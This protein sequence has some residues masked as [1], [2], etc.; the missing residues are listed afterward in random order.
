MSAD[1][2]GGAK[3]FDFGAHERAAV[4]AYAGVIARII[5]ECLKKRNIK[6]HSVQHRAKEPAS[7]GRKASIPSEDDPNAAKYAD[8]IKQIT[9]LA[10]VRIITHFLTTLADV[11][12]LLAEEFEVNERSDKGEELIEEERFGYQSVHFLVKIKK[13]RTRLA[14]YERF[15]G[16][17]AEVQVRTILQHAWAEIEHDIQYKSSKTIPTEIRR[18]FMAL[19]G[20]LEIADREFQAIQDADKEIETRAQAQVQSGELGGVEITPYALKL[21]LDARLGPDARISEWGYDWIARLI[22]RLGFRDLKQ[23]EA[24]I[25]PYDDDHL[26]RLA[27]GARQGQ[28]TRFELMLLAALGDRF[29]ERHHWN[30][31]EWFR[32][33]SRTALAVFQEAGVKTATYD[34]ESSSQSTAPRPI[35]KDPAVA[36]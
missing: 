3:A 35:P 29:I 8:P 20:M 25:A 9:D 30:I 33:Q 5:E 11:D 7:L 10:G 34:P 6:V 22:K 13:D 2:N 26:S 17:I 12:R 21:F 16:A 24:A 23:V 18:R 32:D 4:Q 31:H 36:V 14:E 15:A 28:V 27:T 19:A 1:Q